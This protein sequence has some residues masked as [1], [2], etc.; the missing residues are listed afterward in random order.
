MRPGPLLALALLA[1]SS[2]AVAQNEA[3]HW[4]YFDSRETPKGPVLV[5][6]SG[7]RETVLACEA[8]LALISYLADGNYGVLER[9]SLSLGDTNRVLLRFPVDGIASVDRAELR[10]TMHLSRIPP[11][12]PFDLAVH[13]VEEAWSEYGATW[14]DQP[15]L[16]VEPSA[17]KRVEPHD[18]EVRID[19]TA[20]V[21]EWVSGATPEHGIC[22]KAL[23]PIGP[24]TSSGSS[25][26]GRMSVDDIDRLDSESMSYAP[27]LDR[28][29]ERA[30]EERRPV[31]AIVTAAWNEDD[32][33]AHE[34]L[35][36]RTVLTQ[37][38]V[39]ELIERRFVLVRVVYSPQVFANPRGD[40][41]RLRR[42]GTWVHAGKAPALVI[43]RPDGTHLATRQSIGTF[44]H[45]LVYQFWGT[46]LRTKRSDRR[47][48]FSVDGQLA[49]GAWSYNK[50]FGETWIGGFGG[51]PE[52]EKGRAH[53]MN[54]G[55]ALAP[56]ARAR[57]A[58]FDVPEEVLAS[59]LAALDDMRV[60]T[61]RYTYTWPEP[62]NFE[63]A[64][65]SIAR[66]PVCEL[67]RMR[68][69]ASDANELGAT[70]DL[71][72]EQRVRLRM[73]VKLTESW[74]PPHGYSS[75][76]YFFAYYHAATALSEL[77]GLRAKRDLEQL[78]V[79]LYAVV[80]ADGT[81]VDYEAIG[82][83]YSTAMALLV[84]DLAARQ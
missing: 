23:D 48:R 8:D 79:D 29:F 2:S 39:R 18:G 19:V 24:P 82:K 60:G 20:L 6:E 53:S 77:G 22:L 64:D 12:A 69:G 57:R 75:Y 42:L 49:S 35:L 68:L 72:M 83:P 14:S 65:A 67:A 9:I 58:G 27:S 28:A 31:L 45:G 16:A 1:T 15:A 66:A 34:K 84:L 41:P 32:P 5:V 78:A 11:V 44:D 71:F 74:L 3:R 7:G 61:G 50:R 56:L 70:L 73:P 40:D 30:R 47:S 62:R 59:G 36:L 55:L 4:V 51:W 26:P 10:L 54:T 17:T 76:F 25:G 38:V 80:E 52:T 63:G 21:A 46:S 81:W 43:A 33:N 37:P 13:R